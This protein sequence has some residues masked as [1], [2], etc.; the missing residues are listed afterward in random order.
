MEYLTSFPYTVC[1][2]LWA[3][4]SAL[5]GYGRPCFAPRNLPEFDID[6]ETG[7]VPPRPLPKLQGEYQIWEDTLPRN[8]SLMYGYRKTCPNG[9]LRVLEIIY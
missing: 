2:Q 4:M 8:S 3:T 6:G 7:F 1:S 9:I 5:T